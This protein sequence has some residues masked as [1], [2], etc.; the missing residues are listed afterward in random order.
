MLILVLF[1]LFVSSS[2][3]SSVSEVVDDVVMFVDDGG[4]VHVN[5]S[6]KSPSYHLKVNGEGV[7]LERIANSVESQLKQSFEM[8]SQTLQMQ[9]TML[10]KLQQSLQSFRD[11]HCVDVDTTSFVAQAKHLGCYGAV[12]TEKGLIYGIPSEGTAVPI[13]DPNTQTYDNTTIVEL[14]RGLNK[15]EGGV[16]ATDGKVFCIPRD[17]N[18]I[19]IID[20]SDNTIEF[21]DIRRRDAN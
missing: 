10:V 13:F 6:G 19:L 7:V 2:S 12:A 16:L 8:Q 9:S 4:D 21:H 14:V 3:V 5:T 1:L 11:V 20:P 18:K 17:F 15:W